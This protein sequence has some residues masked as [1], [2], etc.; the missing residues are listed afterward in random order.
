[1]LAQGYITDRVTE[2]LKSEGVEHS[3]VN[4]GEIRLI[5]RRPDGLC[6]VCNG[7]GRFVDRFQLDGNGRNHSSAL[8]DRQ[9]KGLCGAE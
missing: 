1:M 2:L 8:K 3:L 4:L 7:C 6:W 9:R 5:G